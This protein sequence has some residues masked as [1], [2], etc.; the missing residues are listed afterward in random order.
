MNKTFSE[1]LSLE[2]SLRKALEAQ[3]FAVFYQLIDISWAISL[4]WKALIHAGII[5]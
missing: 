2:T 1:W 5:R 4:A 3:Q